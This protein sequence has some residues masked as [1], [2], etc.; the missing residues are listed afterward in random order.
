MSTL[1]PSPSNPALLQ[2]VLTASQNGV[3]VYRAVRRDDGLITDLR[4]TM[5]NAVA[6][7]DLGKAAIDVLGQPFSRLVPTMVQLG[8]FDRFRQVLDTGQSIRFEF[9][10]TLPGQPDPDWL[11]ISVVPMEDSVVV[12]YDNITQAKATADAARQASV[13]EQSFGA[14][15]SGVTVYETI[16]DADGRISDFCFVMINEAGLR[17]SGGYARDDMSGGYTRAE[18]L[19]RTVWQIYPATSI[20]GLFDQYVQVCQTGEPISGEKHYPESD[21]WREYIIVPVVGGVMVTYNDITVR[22][23]LEDVARQQ[24]QLLAGILEGVP[25]GIAVLKAVRTPAHPTGHITDFCIVRINSAFRLA[26]APPTTE[27]TDQ[28]L[29]AFF[30]QVRESGLLSRCIMCVETG[31]PHE[32]GMPLGTNGDP[33]WYQASM[34]LEGDQLILSLTDITH[35]RRNKLAHHFQAELLRSISDNT[36]A[37]LVLWEA[38]RD[39]TPQQNLT[40]FRYRMANRMNSHLTGYA[41]ETLI[42]NDLLTLFPHFR[43]TELETALRDTLETGR[44]QRLLFTYYTDQPGRWFDAQFNR[45]GGGR[46]ANAVLMTYMDVTDRHNAQLAQQ[47]QQQALE[48]ANLNLRRSNE[49]LQQFAYVAS[50]DLQEPLRK[51][52]SFGSMLATTYESVLD[53]AGQDMIRRM[54]GSAERM[55]MLIR[56]LLAY[57]RL[58]TQRVP[59]YRLSLAVVLNRVLG[60]LEVT[61][62]ETGAII[63]VADLPDVTGDQRQLE[64]LMLNLLSNALKFRRAGVTPHIRVVGQRVPASIVPFGV[65]PP[66][67]TSRDYTEISVA[68]NGIGFDEKYLDRIF[69]VFQRLH[70]K[71]EYVG[72]GVGLAICRKVVDNH[73]GG[74][75]ASSQPGVGATFSVYLPLEEA[76]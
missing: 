36:P 47:Q 8:L 3:L 43:G 70:G 46:S 69:Q 58:A 74:I 30:P 35:T 33:H 44:T 62:Q 7:R 10:H 42:G 59:Y 17:M 29:T 40:D 21:I 28:Q 5:L 67:N 2:R 9:Q 75:T 19:G 73:G 48:V 31:R 54:Q 6:E 55:S 26:F 15:I 37:G 61:I 51:I 41:E 14:S 18:L 24:A 56:D 52:Q 60:D 4:L 66:E 65:L 11:D 68:D 16:Y 64:Q 38:V 39:D 20:N 32:F 22:K 76:N 23:K 71:S 50:H 25:V 63:D 1:N 13:F 53:A 57:S 45:I 27:V 12:S 72:S 34:T 49:N